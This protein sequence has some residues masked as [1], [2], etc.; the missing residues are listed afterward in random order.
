MTT[1]RLRSLTLIRHAKS[2]WDH[3]EL[4]DFDRPLN[5]RGLR[6]APM[7]GK[8]LAAAG[9][10]ADTIISSPARRAL[11]TAESIAA[12]IGF[13]PDNIVQN[14][15]VYGAGPGALTEVLTGI[16]E[17][18]RHAVLVG[19]NPGITHL[20]NFLC[21]SRIDSLPTCSIARIEFGDLAWEDVPRQKGHLIEFDYPRKM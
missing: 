19:H 1:D 6:N 21:D 11:M 9:Y 20:C 7:M 13:D 15:L 3:P 10:R 17:R 5:P 8:R 12:E 4:Q 2:S 16:S 14:P 18:F